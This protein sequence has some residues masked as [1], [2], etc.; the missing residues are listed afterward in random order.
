MQNHL[1]HMLRLKFGSTAIAVMSTNLSWPV[2]S[3]VNFFRN[4]KDLYDILYIVHSSKVN[5]WE[6]KIHDLGQIIW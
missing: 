4:R 5:L 6:G 3:R 1:L 2:Y